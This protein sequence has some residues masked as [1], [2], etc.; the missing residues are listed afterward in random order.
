[1]E[2][3]AAFQEYYQEMLEVVTQYEYPDESCAGGKYIFDEVK[4]KMKIDEVL[5]GEMW[6]YIPQ[7]LGK[8]VQK[9]AEKMILECRKNLEK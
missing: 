6:K 3:V 7:V 2:A 9:H 4:E 8:R 5:L 1:Y